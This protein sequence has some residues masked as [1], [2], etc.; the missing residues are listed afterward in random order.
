M[1]WDV[2]LLSSPNCTQPV[3]TLCGSFTTRNAHALP[4]L[5]SCRGCMQ[6][7]IQACRLW[8][9]SGA[10]TPIVMER[11]ATRCHRSL[12][13]L[14]L[15]VSSNQ[16]HST[17]ITLCQ[18][19]PHI[20]AQRYISTL[21]QRLQFSTHRPPLLIAR[22][23]KTFSWT[24]RAHY[25]ERH[26]ASIPHAESDN[27]SYDGSNSNSA[28]GVS[29]SNG[30]KDSTA[31]SNTGL[32]QVSNTAESVRTGFTLPSVRRT[33]S[34]SSVSQSARSLGAAGAPAA[35]QQASDG[36]AIANLS[37]CGKCTVTPT[38]NLGPGSAP[39][40]SNCDHVAGMA[41]SMESVGLS[42]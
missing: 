3:S 16:Y 14:L 21:R 27:A 13:P 17:A 39:I 26:T 36:R 23:A 8:F 4:Q 5:N 1:T 6:I 30:D 24:Q 22:T 19:R 7:F 31:D 29:G 15:S 10:R 20:Q 33:A 37:R 42:Q 9:A 2:E 40:P 32:D 18:Q 41:E 12:P 38:L 28:E 11:M 25:R 35:V 34:A